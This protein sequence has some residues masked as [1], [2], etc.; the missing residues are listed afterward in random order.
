MAEMINTA[1]HGRSS[2]VPNSD[3]LTMDVNAESIG[4]LK[5][6]YE[7][8]HFRILVIGRANAGKT[9][10]LEKICGVAQGTKPIIYSGSKNCPNVC[11]FW[12]DWHGEK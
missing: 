4:M 7:C 6:Q 3:I 9:T 5:E 10:I 2:T 8:C 1:P 11:T 12:K